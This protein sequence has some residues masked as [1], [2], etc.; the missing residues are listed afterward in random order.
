MKKYVFLLFL[1]LNILG[2]IDNIALNK[3]VFCSSYMDN[4]PAILAID[5]DNNS[6]W[7]SGQ[8]ANGWIEIDLGCESSVEFV[9][10]FVSQNPSGN[11]THELYFGDSSRNYS[12]I[13]TFIGYTTDGQ[14]LKYTCSNAIS[15]VRYVKVVTKHSPSWV[16]WKEIKVMGTNAEM[17]KIK[18]DQNFKGH[19]R[20]FGYHW[21]AGDHG[22]MSK[23]NYMSEFS[24]HCNFVFISGNEV[25]K[26]QE[27]KERNMKAILYCAN[28]LFKKDETN[29]PIFIGDSIWDE[30]ANIIAPYVDN[31]LA[32][33]PVDEPF[34]HGFTKELCKL[35]ND[36]IKKRFP[37]IP[38]IV[39]F[40]YK[41]MSENGWSIP[42]GYDWITFD[43]YKDFDDIKTGF[44]FLKK[45]INTNQ[46]IFLTPEGCIISKPPSYISPTIYR[47]LEIVNK[48]RQYYNLARM[49]KE[50]IGLFTFLWP[51][52]STENLVPSEEAEMAIG[53]RDMEIVKKEYQRIGREIINGGKP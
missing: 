41:S 40:A 49:N 13:Y 45:Q 18:E 27:A 31:I 38:I 25:K 26:L 29:T 39:T 15:N 32:F 6:T 47:Q 24:D 37:S 4:Y 9:S 5:G 21:G 14:E 33:Y 16:S 42:E 8:Y 50:V 34:L 12:L 10:L 22:G 3:P 36:T 11:T 44:E 7:N 19:L 28:Y 35:G 17:E 48:A 1:C 20:Y 53:V 2:C 46:K 43:I 23:N 30:Y 51:S 52:F